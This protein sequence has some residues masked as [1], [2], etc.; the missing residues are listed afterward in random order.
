MFGPQDKERTLI[1]FELIGR[2]HGIPLYFQRLPGNRVS[3]RLAFFVGSMDDT[4]VGGIN[5]HGLAHWFEHVPFRGTRSYPKGAD[6]LFP[7]IERYGGDL[8]AST[9]QTKTV[10]HSVVPRSIWPQ[11]L[12]IVTDLAGCPLMTEAGIEA[13]RQVIYSEIGQARAN[14]GQRLWQELLPRLWPD[15]PIG[16]TVRGTKESLSQ[17]GPETVRFAHRNLYDRSRA[18][19]IISGD[20]DPSI[21]MLEATKHLEKIQS[22]G[23]PK[24]SGPVSYGQLPTWRPRRE[25][26]ETE[27]EA[28]LVAMAWPIS[29]TT[30]SGAI[31]QTFLQ[32]WLGMVFSAGSLSSPLMRKLR[33]ERQLV[34]SAGSSNFFP[35]VDGG[36]FVLTAMTKSRDNLRSIIDGFQ[37]VASSDELRSENWHD[38]IADNISG[39]RDMEV[40]DAHD[41]TGTLL[42]RLIVDG[43]DPLSDDEWYEQYLSLDRSKIVSALDKLTLDRACIFT[44]EGTK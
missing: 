5:G 9:G 26:I 22:H 31:E 42:S 2:P 41:H 6:D 35:S 44:L 15:H 10:Y 7:T 36:V 19:L 40:M 14:L 28:S 27:F 33:T 24:R 16:H 21:V 23:L 38:Y 34:Y 43:V 11:A 8:N 1:N 39:F 12:D 3:I 18:V 4:E 32:K 29:D 17:M 13:E 25:D 30:M 20:I 37:E